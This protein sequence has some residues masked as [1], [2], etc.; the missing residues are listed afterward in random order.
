[1]DQSLGSRPGV[2]L[3]PMTIADLLDGAFRLLRSNARVIITASAIFIVPA[4]LVSLLVIVSTG[5]FSANDAFL[6][7]T[8]EV[9]VGEEFSE[10]PIFTESSIPFDGLDIVAM[11]FSSLLGALSIIFVGAI[12]CQVAIDAYAGKESTTGSVLGQVKKKIWSLMGSWILVHLVEASGFLIAFIFILAA[13][14]SSG[15]FFFVIISFI[16]AVPIY[17]VTMILSTLVTPCLMGEDL[18]AITSMKRSWR[19]VRR[20]FWP[21][22]WVTFLAGIITSLVGNILGF[23][24]FFGMGIGGTVGGVIVMVTAMLV[25]FITQPFTALVATLQYLN[26]RIRNEGLDL[27]IVADRLI[28]EHSVAVNG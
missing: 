16:L 26:C 9:I 20:R 17:L 14:A 6:S 15:A 28:A 25:L 8:D 23:P 27:E 18:G 22:V 19:L 4:Q 11:G 7:T 10:E 3:R 24:M 5:L 2:L 12:A 13:T 21:I 1:M